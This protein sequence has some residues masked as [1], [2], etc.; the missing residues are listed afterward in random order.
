MRLGWSWRPRRLSLHANFL[1]E[2]P[3]GEHPDKIQ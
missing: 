1:T 2:S 3:P